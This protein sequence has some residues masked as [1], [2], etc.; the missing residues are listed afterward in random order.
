MWIILEEDGS[1]GTHSCKTYVGRWK[2]YDRTYLIHSIND[3]PCATS[4]VIAPVVRES[5][6]V[7]TK[8]LDVL[9]LVVERGGG[10]SLGTEGAEEEDCVMT[11]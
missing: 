9:N 6:M 4:L 1:S 7:S 11:L 2:G 10:V 5:D 3:N 8:L